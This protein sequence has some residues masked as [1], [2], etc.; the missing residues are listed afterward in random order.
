MAD[1]DVGVVVCMRSSHN[2]GSTLSIYNAYCIPIHIQLE[3]LALSIYQIHL[4]MVHCCLI[5]NCELYTFVHRCCSVR[6]MLLIV[7]LYTFV[8]RCCERGGVEAAVA[9]EL[10]RTVRRS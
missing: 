8:H 5:L 3:A 6:C 2:A 10:R 7:E 9:E 1:R 4:I